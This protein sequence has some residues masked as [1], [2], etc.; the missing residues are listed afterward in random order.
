MENPCKNYIRTSFSLELHLFH[1]SVHF[2]FNILRF[3]PSCVFQYL[4]IVQYQ[5]IFWHK[6]NSGT[7]K[8]QD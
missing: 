4:N 5:N 1:G 3:S 7:L 8:N 6:N 2:F